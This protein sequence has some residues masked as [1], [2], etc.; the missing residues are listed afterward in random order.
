RRVEGAVVERAADDIYLA[1][2]QLAG[3]GRT[4]KLPLDDSDSLR[5]GAWVAAVGHG[6][7]GIW[8]YSVGMVSN[9]YPSGAQRP[10][11]QT[12][13]PL[14]PGSSGGPMIDRRGRV[15][16]VTTAGIEGANNV[17]F[18]IRIDV[19]FRSLQMMAAHCQCL[20]V[21]APNGVPV[22]VDGKMA[23]KGPRLVVPAA[24][25]D[26]EVFVVHAGKMVKQKVSF[27]AVREVKLAA[28]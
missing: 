12:Q 22:F 1:L 23:G 24:A 6:L 10:V 3:A 5:V 4:P 17:N 19:A 15:V 8:T 27:P 18:G 2:V 25:R 13:I 9:I 7:G 26:Y 11:F 28:E 20:V 21:H 14:N 16:G